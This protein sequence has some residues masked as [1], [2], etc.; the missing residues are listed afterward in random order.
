MGSK[1]KEIREHQVQPCVIYVVFCF[2]F[3]VSDITQFIAWW[4]DGHSVWQLVTQRQR[5]VWD[6]AMV[7]QAHT[8]RLRGQTDMGGWWEGK[9]CWVEAMTFT[10]HLPLSV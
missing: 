5:P 2:H 9:P 7:A 8:H 10:E 3:T 4:T 1:N 6:S